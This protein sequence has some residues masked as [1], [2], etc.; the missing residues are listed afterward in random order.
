MSG[1][2]LQNA[3][4]N[5]ISM[6]DR[7]RRDL[8]ECIDKMRGPKALVLDPTLSGPLGLIAEKTL[9]KEHGVEKTY[10][11]RHEPIETEQRRILFLVRDKIPNM[12]AIA[13][14]VKHQKRN[15]QKLE[16]L[17]IMVPRR[18]IVCERV[19]E[20][21]G[22]YADVQLGEYDLD[23]IPCEEDV[24]SME[25]P[26]AYR[27]CHLDGDKSSL[28]YAAKGLMRMQALFGLIPLIKGKGSNA[29]AL[30]DMLLRMRREL[31]EQEE[32]AV[33]A[34]I[35]ELILIDRETDMVT[36]MLTQLTYE[37]LI[38]DTFALNNGIVELPGHLISSGGGG[39][40]ATPADKKAKI[41]VLFGASDVLFT[42]L[43]DANFEQVGSIVKKR[44]TFLKSVQDEKD[45]LQGK[46][47]NEIK[48]Y[49]RKLKE[50]NI[51]QEKNLL[52]LHTSI[53]L[54]I[55]GIVTDYSFSRR[56]DLEQGILQGRIG[57][58]KAVEH[59]QDLVYQKEPFLKMIRLLCLCSYCCNG[60]RKLKDVKQDL[61]QV[62]GF[63]AML[64]LNNLEKLGLLKK[65]ESVGGIAG[66]P[67]LSVTAAGITVAANLTNKIAAT[68]GWEAVKKRLH[69]V[70][71]GAEEAANDVA[72]V[73]S[74]YAPISIRLVER[75]LFPPVGGWMSLEETLKP[76]PGPLFELHQEPTPAHTPGFD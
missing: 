76:L 72:Y 21:E 57:G 68:S 13:S 71:E 7:A 50:I 20:E 49:V 30:A 14:Q 59:I 25:I 53:A 45:E 52:S 41:K 4:V 8:T 37:G 33:E 28:F 19:L 64:V 9:L 23:L 44:A 29:K 48:E 18:T 46:S 27:E 40:Q 66:V 31:G 12:K 62:Y 11:L 26:D 17:V 15:R 42:Q 16:Y 22:A 56:L 32:E 5:L 54:E 55:K 3:A 69:V 1:G 51:Q 65:G 2:G 63:E 24:V 39:A 74:G 10:H 6:R 73:Y 60:I 47:V 38:D 75:A 58:D 35:D 36:P 67:G 34:E 43:R 70:V 61:V